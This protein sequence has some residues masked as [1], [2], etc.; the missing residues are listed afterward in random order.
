MQQ[1]P[2]EPGPDEDPVSHVDLTQSHEEVLEYWTKQRMAEA[3]PREIQLPEP[4][5]GSADQD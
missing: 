4:G 1:N 5:P 3:K 2:K